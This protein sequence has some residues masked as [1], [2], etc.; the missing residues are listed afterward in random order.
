MAVE[1]RFASRLPSVLL[2]GACLAALWGCAD[3]TVRHVRAPDRILEP[4]PAGYPAGQTAHFAESLPELL[5]S[6][7]AASF[8][9]G[10]S[11]ERLRPGEALVFFTASA[12]QAYQ[13]LARLDNADQTAA[14]AQVLYNAALAHCLRLATRQN[15]FDAS[16]TLDLHASAGGPVP[17][18]H[19][20]FNRPATSFGDIELCA[21]SRVSG[22]EHQF[23]VDGAGVPVMLRNTDS[24]VR[25][26][27]GY[28]PPKA[29]FAATAVLHFEGPEATPSRLE[30]LNPLTISQVRVQGR[31]MLLAADLTTPLARMVADADL[32]RLSI[33]GFLRANRTE[34]IRGIHMIEPYEPGKIP[35]ILVHGLLSS[36]ITWAPLFNELRG[37]PLL[38]ERFQ[39][40]ACYYPTGHPVFRNAAEVR[41]ELARLRAD[42]DPDH[43]DPA[44][45]HMVLIGHSMGG[46]IAKLV[47]QEG[48][49]DFWRLVSARPVDDYQLSPTVRQRLEETLLFTRQKAVTRVVFIGTPHH[50]AHMGQSIPA[51]IAERLIKFRPDLDQVSKELA[52]RIPDMPYGH[53]PTSVEELAPN[54][55]AL[56]ILA[57]RPAPPGVHYHSIIGVKPKG[58]PSS[59]RA[60]PGD[61]VVAYTSAH[62]DGVESELVVPANHFTVHQN[63]QTFQEIRRILLEHLADLPETL[64]HRTEPSEDRNP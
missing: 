1:H 12:G 51:W 30:L 36:P 17:V 21:D 31:P 9:R 14:R 27:H 35:V 41:D 52:Q 5:L 49:P 11:A 34:D 39:F 20:G 28:F 43:R 19:T 48:G 53:V 3:V 47:T 29:R 40:W 62:L 58:G 23:H 13:A 16:V 44:L 37:D 54:S 63:Q 10:R 46:L 33:L 57:A 25:G 15:H 22:L 60:E 50:G 59:R 38:R 64:V 4:A 2:L 6:Y 18:T 7:S 32:L 56:R 8:A 42:F 61:G 55:L 45:D 24:Y 26:G